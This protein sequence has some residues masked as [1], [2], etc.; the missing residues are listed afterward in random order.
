MQKHHHHIVRH[1]ANA[2][3][4]VQ[5]ITA[6]IDLYVLTLRIPKTYLV[7]KQLLILEFVVQLVEGTFYVWLVRSFH[8]IENITPYRYYD[9]YLTTPTMLITFSIY[10]IY[11]KTKENNSKNQETLVEN[12]EETSETQENKEKTI[13]IDKNDGF[14]TILKNNSTV[15]S[16]ILILNVIML[17][18]GMLNEHRILNK[19]IAV[20][21]GFIPFVMLFYLIYENYAKY[22]EKG[23]NLFVYFATI[24]SFYGVAALMPYHWK[25][26]AYNILDLFSKNFFGIYLAYIL[27]QVSR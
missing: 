4:I 5:V 10:L 12:Q 20:F 18:F 7:L 11:L 9:W 6:I 27:W 15:L 3:L 19:Y 25:N 26:I 2:S 13:D 21:G 24:W 1:S 23:R 17:T 14:F 8:S 22:S 16:Y